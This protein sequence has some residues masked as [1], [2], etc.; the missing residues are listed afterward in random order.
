MPAGVRPPPGFEQQPQAT[1]PK[2]K[3]QIKGRKARS[4]HNDYY[5]PDDDEDDLE[6]IEKEKSTVPAWRKHLSDESHPTETTSLKKEVKI[7]LTSAQREAKDLI[8]PRDITP[9]RN[10][11]DQDQSSRAPST[12]EEII[13]SNRET[14]KVYLY[15]PNHI[16]SSQRDFA[17]LN[18]FLTQLY[19][20]IL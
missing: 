4:F 5:Q 8:T 7:D 1:Q 10:M 12:K 15:Y 13:E 20:E 14:K 2:T 9:N 3:Y 6:G 18:R 11:E 19:F 16:Q 17:F